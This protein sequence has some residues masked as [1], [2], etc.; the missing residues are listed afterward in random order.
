MARVWTE[1]WEFQDMVGYC[2]GSDFGAPVV[3]ISILEKRS[4]NASM[5][6]GNISNTNGWLYK[7]I[8]PISE[9]YFRFAV[10]LDP[11]VYGAKVPQ[12]Q[13][14]AGDTV[15][16]YITFGSCY[17]LLFYVGGVLADYGF[18]EMYEHIWYL[19]EVH[20]KVSATVG[21]CEVMLD[22]KSLLEID[23]AGNT[24]TGTIDNIKFW[25]QTGYIGEQSGAQFDD[26]GLNDTA[27]G[28]DDSWC[29]EGKIVVMMPND[30]S[31]PL[32]LTPYPNT[33]EHHHQDVDEIPTDSGTT[34]VE[35][36]VIN[37]ED[38]YKLTPCGLLNVDINRVWAEARSMKTS[39]VDGHVAL[40]TKAA[41]GAEVSGG[42]VDLLTT[43]TIKVLGT[44][45]V[46][47]PVDTNPWEVADID[48]IEIGP[49]T[50]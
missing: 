36:S 9:F 37:E 40:I 7:N 31:A 13:F 43:Y 22:G 21:I 34:Y 1:G 18:T 15:K 32:Q 29:G 20:L 8:D 42:D 23:F 46:E 6:I 35:G 49:R 2:T 14:R 25:I 48:L 4:G 38:M 11:H 26:I 3:G 33:G 5:H 12:I 30:D 10:R 44:E 50:R 16:S 45:Q 19:V 47:N 28:V 41:G 24:G 39:A 27:G 17:N